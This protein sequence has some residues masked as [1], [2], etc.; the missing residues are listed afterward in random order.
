MGRTNGYYI[1]ET[2]GTSHRMFSFDMIFQL[3]SIKQ[4]DDA[5]AALVVDSRQQHNDVGPTV[6]M[7][8]EKQLLA[9]HM[10]LK[11]QV[12]DLIHR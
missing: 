2:K 8:E 7:F 11:E 9:A 12:C 5:A 4:Q 6:E 3:K 10:E 1:V